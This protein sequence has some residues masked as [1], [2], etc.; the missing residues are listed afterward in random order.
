MKVAEIKDL[1]R[2]E[3]IGAHSHI[4]GLGLDDALEARRCRE[5]VGQVNARKAAGVVRARI[6]DAT[7]V[8]P[9]PHLRA[10]P[11]P[12]VVAV[13]EGRTRAS[14]AKSPRARSRS[15]GTD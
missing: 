7:I 14:A 6:R 12:H 13:Y 4:R 8:F 5:M 2:I 9:T 10:S 3:R 11:D 1:T 15:R